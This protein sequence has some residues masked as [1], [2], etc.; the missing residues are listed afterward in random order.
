LGVRHFL[1]NGKHFL[2]VVST[3]ASIAAVAAYLLNPHPSIVTSNGSSHTTITPLVGVAGRVLLG[4][5][6]LARCVDMVRKKK[7][8]G[9]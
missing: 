8:Q 5:L 4:R 6:A 7:W 1:R 3:A 9:V 2:V